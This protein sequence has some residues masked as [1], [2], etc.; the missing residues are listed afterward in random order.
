MKIHKEWIYDVPKSST[1]L[2]Q[3]SLLLEYIVA[4]NDRAKV[5]IYSNEMTGHNRPHVHAFYGQE[6]FVITID[7]KLDI[8]HGNRNKIKLAKYIIDNLIRKDI[9]KFRKYWNEIKSNYKFVLRDNL[10]VPND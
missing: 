10:L 3:K 6:E 5:I 7:D 4:A 8:I 9:Q 1:I 2:G